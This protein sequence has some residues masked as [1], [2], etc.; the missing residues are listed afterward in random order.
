MA[1]ND[2]LES[3]LDK[4]ADETDGKTVSVGDLLDLYEDRTFGPIFTFLG[5]LVVLPPLGAI[6]GLP[7]VI[8]MLL[9]L[10]AFQMMVGSSHP[11]VPGFVESLSIPKTK[12]RAAREKSSGVLGRLDSLLTERLAWAVSKPARII[13]A[14]IVMVL[15]LAMIPLEL[16]PFAVG[17]PGLAITLIG[18]AIMARDGL[19]MLAALALGLVAFGVLA[20]VMLP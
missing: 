9:V 2:P 1:E 4:A 11:W 13:S 15:A 19:L 5:L 17:L 12:V 7:V 3:I 14:G 18:L 8:G 10:F 20:G 6:P 16:I